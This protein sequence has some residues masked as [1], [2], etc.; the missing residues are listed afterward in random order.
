MDSTV[1]VSFTAAVRVLLAALREALRDH[2]SF[3]ELEAYGRDRLPASRRD[4]LAEHLAVCMNCGVL[5]R[6]GVLEEWE[7]EG[8]GGNG[9]P[10]LG[11]L[12]LEQAWG[13]L[14]RQLGAGSRSWRPLSSA[15]AEG[16]LPLAEVLAVGRKVAEALADYHASGGV[17]RDLR[18]ETVL[19]DPEEGD[20]SFFDL[21]IAAVPQSLEADNGRSAQDLVADTVRGASPEQVAGE[22]LDQRSN[23]FSLGSLLYEMVTGISPFRGPTPL[24]TASRVLALEAL[25]AGKVREDVPPALDTLLQCLLS[26]DPDNRPGSAAAVAAA[27]EAIESGAANPLGA[28]TEIDDLDAEIEA[29][30]RRIDTLTEAKKAGG[31][32]EVEAEIA[33]AFAQLRKLQK[34]EAARFRR[35]FE[36]RLAMPVDAGEKIL[37]RAAC[38]KEK[39]ERL[40]APY[41]AAD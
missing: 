5:L 20:V 26:K 34:A 32:A 36:A 29:L 37:N 18:P 15:L 21:G 27:L 28:L 23:L 9:P 11:K 4:E 25:P 40:T 35:E 2:P 16:R 13:A 12:D 3:E 6:Y 17:I 38:L 14:S 33:G 7:P 30:Y 22:R 39:L 1:K 41:P 24:E 8:L 10:G 31:D 19:V